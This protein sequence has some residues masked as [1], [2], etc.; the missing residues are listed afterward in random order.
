MRYKIHK[1]SKAHLP[2]VKCKSCGDT[3]PLKSNASI[4]SELQR[5]I[6]VGGLHTLAES[7]ACRNPECENHAR[8]IAYHRKCYQKSSKAPGGGQYYICK[9]CGRYVLLSDPVR[10]HKTHRALAVDV[11][12]R[13]ANKAPM[14][15]AVNGARLKSPGAYYRILNFIE[16]RCRTFSGT[17]D[18]AMLDGRVRLPQEIVV[19]ADAQVYQLNWVSRMDRR[20][21]DLS[22]YCSIDSAS[23][24]IFGMHSN[25]DP[26]VD[27]FEVNGEA[28]DSGDLQ[29]AEPFRK[30]AQYW[31]AGDELLAGR[32]MGRTVAN[33]M[34][35]FDQ[36]EALYSDASSRMDVE[37]IELQHLNDA[38]TTP[39]LKNGLQVH[40]PYLAYAHWLLLRRILTGAGVRKVQ[41]CM[42][43]DSMSRA[44]F[45]CAFVDE[46]KRG[47]AHLFFV[48]FKK[49]V[50]KLKRISLEKQGKDA[51]KAFAETLPAGIRDDW[52]EVTRRRM[53]KVLSEGGAQHGKW[54]DTWYKHPLV[55]L[56]E[57]EKA[58]SWMT[59]TDQIDDTRKADMFL[60]AA[61]AHVNN[62]FQR[63]RRLFNPLERPLD[64]PGGTAKSTWR[65]YSPYNPEVVQKYL[66]LFRAVH[67]FVWI[68]EI[69]KATPAMR[70][71]L[72]KQ[73]LELEDI[74]WPGQKVPRLNFQTK[75]SLIRP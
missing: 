54:R 31:L 25:F 60:N 19:E 47:D 62:V 52:Q 27:P 5:I 59:P 40:M 66:T 41:A 72:A 53:L 67:N 73:P 9:A 45:L 20:N 23:R 43:V 42:D 71:G 37:N 30:F 55:T 63:T 46:I 61:L 39:F 38:Y 26:E 10:L 51:L 44:A 12:G 36:V 32:A 24:F 50:S 68:S 16:R 34:G 57:P 6:R 65:G 4:A 49:G 7:V 18:R 69:D 14:R 2:S 17:Y 58:V 29:L 35:L 33:R 21:V 48:H 1:S 74:L 22:T 75:P 15:R 13:I 70:L 11:F 64:V 3:P 56:N 8:P 28:A